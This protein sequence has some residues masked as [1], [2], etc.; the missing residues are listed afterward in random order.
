LIGLITVQNSVVDYFGHKSL[1]LLKLKNHNKMVIEKI[2]TIVGI[3]TSIFW[4]C[5]LVECL[6][7]FHP[8]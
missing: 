8:G 6:L 7:L 4:N 1:W 5:S 3:V 2:P